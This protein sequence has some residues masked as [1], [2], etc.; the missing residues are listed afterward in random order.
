MRKKTILT[1]VNFFGLILFLCSL[2]ITFLEI[3]FFTRDVYFINYSKQKINQVIK[4]NQKLESQLWELNSISNLD[5]FLGKSSFTKA[6]KI[7]FIQMI[8]ERV[9]A[10]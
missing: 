3:G 7:K 4:E 10:K 6:E 1:K 8:G 5:Q 2:V 9:V